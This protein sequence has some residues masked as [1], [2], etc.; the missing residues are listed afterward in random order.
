MTFPEH[1][2]GTAAASALHTITVDASQAGGGVLILS[3]GTE[4]DM[5]EVAPVEIELNP[6]A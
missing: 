6:E 3:L 5:I 1:T 2:I 4:E